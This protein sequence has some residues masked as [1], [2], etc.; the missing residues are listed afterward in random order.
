MLLD[1]WDALTAQQKSELVVVQSYSEMVELSA[2]A[3]AS[4][5]DTTIWPRV[6]PFSDYPL[7]SMVQDLLS[8]K[9]TVEE[10]RQHQVAGGMGYPDN[11]ERAGVDRMSRASRIMAALAKCKDKHEADEQQRRFLSFAAD[12]AECGGDYTAEELMDIY[13]ANY[14]T[15]DSQNPKMDGTQLKEAIAD[16]KE[17]LRVAAK[18]CA[19]ERKERENTERAKQAERGSRSKEPIY[20]R[21]KVAKP[22]AQPRIIDDD[23][24][25]A[26]QNNAVMGG[27]ADKLKL[28]EKLAHDKLVLD[29]VYGCDVNNMSY[30]FVP[31]PD[32]YTDEE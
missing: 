28:A 2:Q 13:V 14:L 16:K 17:R 4:R 10:G 26:K 25:R 31:P 18:A 6:G 7:T 20:K 22:M 15:S 5:Q 11:S 1:D 32:Y 21:T 27:E 29:K 23:A 30:N 8:T 3:R 9:D 12:P 24:E 19:K